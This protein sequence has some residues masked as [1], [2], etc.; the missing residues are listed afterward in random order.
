[1]SLNSTSALGTYGWDQVAIS[2]TGQTG[3]VSGT[4]SDASNGSSVDL[5]HISIPG[6][7]FSGLEQMTQS[8]PAK[9]T[10]I[11]A[12]IASQLRSA[13]GKST[14]PDQA[15]TL[16]DMA[17]T[18]AKTSMTAQYSD[19]FSDQGQATAVSEGLSGQHQDLHLEAVSQIFSNALSQMPLA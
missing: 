4:S 1:M 14:D 12:Q 9:F 3:A 11:T 17:G 10:S 6:R 7:L 16:K 19:L 15:S 5:A 18:F 13:A 8:N 2:Y